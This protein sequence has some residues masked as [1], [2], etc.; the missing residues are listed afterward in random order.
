MSASTL[1]PTE[2]R[3]SLTGPG[4]DILSV[5]SSAIWAEEKCNGILTF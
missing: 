1:P 5:T 2:T 3:Q 4:G